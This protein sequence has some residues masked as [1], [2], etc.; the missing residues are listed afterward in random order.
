MR[1]IRPKEIQVSCSHCNALLGI[2]ENDVNIND[3]GHGC[4]GAYYYCHC[5]E[6][7]MLIKLDGKI[8]SYWNIPGDY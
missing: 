1:V 3:V 2:S 7:G 4:G 5:R 6:C 8:P